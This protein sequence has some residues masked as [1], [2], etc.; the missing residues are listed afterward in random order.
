MPS[1]DALESRTFQPDG[2]AFVD[3]IMKNVTSARV[4]NVE[5]F[6]DW[7]IEQAIVARFDLADGLDPN[8]P[9]FARRSH[10]AFARFIG[11]DYVRVGLVE[12]NWTFKNASTDD[13]AEL[14]HEGGRSYRDEHTGP[15]IGWDD[16]ERYA[17][18]DPTAPEA[19]R[20]LEWWNANLP[21]DMCIVASGGIGHYAEYI[22]WLLGYETLCFAL[23]D[24]RD[25]VTAIAQKLQDY[26]RVITK[27]IL[28]FD[29]VT[30]VWG[31][32]DMGY[33]TGLMIAPD[34]TREFFLPGHKQTA[35]ASHAAGRP[36]L[37]HSCGKLDDIMPD[38]LDDVQ[39]D[40]LHSFE[41]TIQDVRDIKPTYG[42]RIA[43][44]G[45]M[46]VDFLCRSD[47]AA[48]RQRTRDTLDVCMPGGRYLLG[49]GNSVTN[50]IPLDNY[51]AM[52]D[53]GMKYGR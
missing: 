16:F 6:H 22:M 15:I 8:D 12:Q 14:G 13:T 18:P 41:D 33:K 31:S 40:A 45:G 46:D 28:D 19:T 26:Y 38:L 20:E 27:R 47:E 3:A 44:L 10:L 50:Y 24:Q 35:A 29:R 5:L 1:F 39:I 9:D 37:L 36:Y 53:E 51:L 17:W 23:F 4:H 11:M 7:E 42:Q 48:I 34:D 43:L 25:L 49:T 21:A 2:Q 52:V 32:D 30:V